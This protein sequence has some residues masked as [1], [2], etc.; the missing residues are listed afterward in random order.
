[1][2]VIFLEL[3]TNIKYNIL[4]TESIIYLLVPNSHATVKHW[5]EYSYGKPNAFF[6]FVYRR[7]IFLFLMV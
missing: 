6:T 5:V 2:S 3:K 7:M 1:M 4:K